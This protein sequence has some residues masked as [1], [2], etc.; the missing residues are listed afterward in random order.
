MSRLW[1]VAGP[2]G[3]LGDLSDRAADALRSCPTWVVE[4]TRVSS[5]LAHHLGVKPRYLVLN[6]HTSSAGLA[7]VVQ[8]VCD[9]ED[10]ALLTDAGMPGISDP[11][12]ELVLA[13]AEEEVD[14]D[15]IP[16]PSAVVTA[17]A[18]SGFFAQRFAFLGFAP[19]KPG[20]IRSLLAPFADST[21]TLVLF[22][23]PHRVSKFA[24]AALNAIG[25]RRAVVARELTKA[26]QEYVRSTLVELSGD[27][28]VWRGEITLVIEGHRRLKQP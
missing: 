21:M 13:C 23:S 15:V 9:A 3:N 11:G 20:D 19:R 27:D 8:S 24:E 7:K 28:R 17:L 10:T 22:E 16:G 2:I 5:R 18:G 25:D 1:V 14:I 26:H 6:D 4:D 12:A